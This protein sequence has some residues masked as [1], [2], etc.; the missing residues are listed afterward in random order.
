M[1]QL[2]LHYAVEQPAWNAHV[3]AAQYFWC[4]QSVVVNSKFV[5]TRL[6]PETADGKR[7]TRVYVD[8]T[9]ARACARDWGGNFDMDE[10]KQ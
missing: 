1:Q 10:R 5:A 7:S 9:C 8:E 2:Q 6:G 3:P 4:C